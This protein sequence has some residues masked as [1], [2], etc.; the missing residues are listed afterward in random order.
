MLCEFWMRPQ[1]RA[2]ST[3]GAFGESA[4]Q[5]Q[6]D[7]GEYVTLAMA[8]QL[9]AEERATSQCPDVFGFGQDIADMQQQLEWKPHSDGTKA[10][11]KQSKKGN[12]TEHSNCV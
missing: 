12:Y 11:S 5:V 2:Q 3:K 8:G 4:A 7:V 10:S 1:Q 6:A 9:G